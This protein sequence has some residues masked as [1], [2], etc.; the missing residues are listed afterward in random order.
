MIHKLSFLGLLLAGTLGL[1]AQKS[2][3]AGHPDEN[4]RKG[5]EMFNKQMYGISRMC[6]DNYRDNSNDRSLLMLNDARYF[7]S[8][9][10]LE[11]F[12][13]NAEIRLLDFVYNTPEDSRIPDAYYRLGIFN[14]R[15]KQYRRVLNYFAK[16]DPYY[17]KDNE[18]CEYYFKKGYSNF[19]L[20]NKDEASNAFYEIKDRESK[21]KVPAIYFYAHIAYEK[22]N[23]E[24]ALQSF[25]SIASDEL[26]APIIPYYITHIYFLQEKYDDVIQ[27][28]PPMLD[29][30]N[31][32]RKPDLARIIGESYYR[33]G[34]FANALPYLEEYMKTSPVLERED[35]FQLG[36]CY[37][38]SARYNDAI[39]SLTKISSEND[40]VY[41]NAA[42]LLGDCY[43]RI[44]DKKSARLA[45][46]AASKGESDKRIQ[47][48]SLFNFAKLTQELSLSPFN[49]AINAFNLFIKKYPES[50]FLD[51]VYTYLSN[52]YISTKNYNEAIDALENIQNINPELEEAYQRVCFF[53]AL[54]LFTN[55]EFEEAIIHFDKSLNNSRY[56]RTYL[57]R[58]IFW[59]GE[60]Y[61]RLSRFDDAA[62]DFNKFLTTTG[63]IELKEF[64]SAHYNMGYCKFKK[65][66][67]KDA[68]SWFRKY[69][70]AMNEA[71]SKTVGDA[72]AR[73]GDCY[74]GIRDYDNAVLFYQKAIDNGKASVDYALYQKGFCLGLQKEHQ[75]K[76]IT[77][78]QLVNDYSRSAY[79][80]DALLEIGNSYIAIEENDMAIN[81]FR[82]LITDFPSSSLV[83]RAY[84][85]TGLVY[86]NT[87]KNQEAMNVLKKAIETY[88][89]SQ[90]TKEALAL[91]KNVYLDMNQVEEYFAYL[92]EKD[93]N[94]D[95]RI[96]EQDSL[97][98]TTA[99]KVYMT[100]DYEKASG[101]FDKYLTQ[102]KEQGIFYVNASYYMAECLKK[103]DKKDKAIAYFE[104][105]VKKPQSEFTEPSLVQLAD[106]NYR[107]QNYEKAAE[108]YQQLDQTAQ[109]DNNKILAKTGKMRC[110]AKNN[111]L[112]EARKAAISL[113][114]AGK[115]SED[116]FREAHYIIGK[117]AMAAGQMEDA[118]DEFM[119]IAG[120]CKAPEQAEAKYLVSLIYYQ[121]NQHDLSEK[122]IFD[123]VK[124][125]TPHQFWLAKSFLLLSDIYLARNNSFQAK[126]TLQSI[127]DNYK[128]TTDGIQEET[129]KKLDAIIQAETP[130]VNENQ[131]QTPEMEINLDNSNQ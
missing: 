128:N 92:K 53:R 15:D 83:P 111:N 47:E 124:K 23:F 56:N 20:E 39:A 93:S 74:Y 104:N 29:S 52:A 110:Y 100:A 69:T 120:E 33:T 55:N 18:Y 35:Y 77:L 107:N 38:Y 112:P 50:P 122:E 129:R 3:T 16:V 6:L 22:K 51:D 11:L 42:Y 119:L 67:F 26:F 96:T 7:A 65:K 41:Q 101:L 85:Q 114:A 45:F 130:P 127:L 121:Q 32:V 99:V 79:V 113:L 24:A 116:L 57:A 78:N 90:E 8:A 87:D 89:R 84:L 68:A 27:Y 17:L 21:F 123:F 98:Y 88:P 14:F 86:Y 48:E 13:S 108:Y 115:L 49:E 72:F 102:Y 94:A 59:R 109:Y 118:L 63:A 40:L 91:L 25:T 71:P 60:A 1:N 30:V 36:F 43:L 64:N 44:Q 62:R 105:V 80:D 81:A 126:A 61:Y 9:C 19:A 103:S 58:S 82:Q 31:P 2:F 73:T 5:V 12:N 106:W 54:E 97:S 95:I 117:D 66:E 37:H 131:N 76:I 75:Q 125:N 28:A 34:K 46:E 4:Y 70:D 10:A